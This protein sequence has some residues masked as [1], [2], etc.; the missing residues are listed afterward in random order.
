MNEI[1]EDERGLVSWS[2][3]RPAYESEDAKKETLFAEEVVAML[4]QYVKMLA[5]KQ[6][7]GRV[8]DCVITVPSWFT[9]DQRLMV[10]DAAEALA[11]LTV[12]Q[13]VHE[14]NAAATMFGIDHKLEQN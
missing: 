8:R 2:F 1:V 14:N 7:D 9:Y 6:A 10:K 11:G 12:L 4:L 3:E 5:E 13:L